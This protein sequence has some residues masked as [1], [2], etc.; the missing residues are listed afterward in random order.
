[1][2]CPPASAI[3]DK[4]INFYTSKTLNPDFLC[5]IDLYCTQS[6]TEET[7][8]LHCSKVSHFLSHWTS[9]TAVSKLLIINKV[10]SL[11]DA[12]PIWHRGRKEKKGKQFESGYSAQYITKFISQRYKLGDLPSRKFIQAR[13][14]NMKHK[15]CNSRCFLSSM[16]AQHFSGPGD[17]SVHTA[18]RS[19]GPC[20]AYSLLKEWFLLFSRSVG[21]T[22]FDPMVC[23]PS[24]SPSMEYPGKNAGCC[25][26]RWSGLLLPS[27]GDL[28]NLRLNSHLLHC[29]GGFFN[30]GANRE[31]L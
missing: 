25:C 30:T 11:E 23:S 6:G 28:P 2:I 10:L 4:A 7:T 14:E 18:D 24:G 27:R 13:T 31:A 20:E 1:M 21:L 26:C 29:V 22:L 9:F 5:I 8:K 17:L 15:W 3:D 12:I 16:K 19:P